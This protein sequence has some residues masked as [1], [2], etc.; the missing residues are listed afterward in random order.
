MTT[1]RINVIHPDDLS[2]TD[3][4]LWDE[5]RVRTAPVANPFMSSQFCQAV[6]RVRP[7]ARVAVVRQ[8]GEP[9]G[10]F[11]FERGRW[12]RGRAIGLGVS[13]CQGAVLRSDL[14]VDPRELL[15]AS[16]LAVWEF[17]HLE[18]G[19]EL[20]LPFATG[21]FASPVVDLS[22]GYGQYETL[23]RTRSR[24]FL[25]S[26]LAQDRRLARHVG[27]LKFVF[28][29]RSPA[30]LRTLMA[31]KSAQYRRTGRRDRFAQTWI[32]NLVR[33]LAGTTAPACSGVLSVL[34]AGDRPVAA[35]F[36]LR[37]RT[38][39][40]CWF[41]AY[42]RNFAKFS[43][44]LVLH[45]R[46]IEAAAAAGIE[47]LDLGRGDAAYKDSLKT[48]ELMVHE[49]ALLRPGPGAVLHR[50]SREPSRAIRRFV[51]E[52]P[53]LKTAAVHTLESVGKMR[54]RRS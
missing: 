32:T 45:L 28:D 23:L 20:F 42:D 31:W 9:A 26:T 10:F 29:E 49:G 37:S 46:M 6:G 53:Q 19:Q 54:D 25:K 22:G 41:P 13:D 1:Q 43:P 14:H 15:R 33:M 3:V 8:D 50:L 27:P 18:S 12:G 48:R 44:G 35:H 51:R 38:V 39:L 40:S 34:Y 30:A 16:A 4:D 52:R 36:G 21:R 47:M 17:N 2:P 24:K 7:G 5:V 11:P